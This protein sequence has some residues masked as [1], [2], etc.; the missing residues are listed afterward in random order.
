MPNLIFAGGER[1]LD[2]AKFCQTVWR[3]ESTSR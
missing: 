2:L 3:V 1:V